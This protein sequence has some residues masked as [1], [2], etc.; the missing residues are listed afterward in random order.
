MLTYISL[1]LG[2]LQTAAVEFDN[3]LSFV[4]GVLGDLVGVWTCCYGR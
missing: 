3:L 2:K 1:E 4:F